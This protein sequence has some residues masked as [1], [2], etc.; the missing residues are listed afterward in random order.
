M[1]GRR[2]I[3]E[4]FIIRTKVAISSKLIER[5]KCG[6]SGLEI[7]KKTLQAHRPCVKCNM[8]KTIL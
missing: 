5:R 4:W 8:P 1:E 2:W 6:L 7:G 3:K